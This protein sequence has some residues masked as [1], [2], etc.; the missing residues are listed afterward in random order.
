[1]TASRKN[2]FEMLRRT[3]DPVGQTLDQAYFA[4]YCTL[5]RANGSHWEELLDLPDGEAMR[6]HITGLMS[7]AVTLVAILFSN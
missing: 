3:Y 6:T 7:S 5:I 1:M 2:S 4:R